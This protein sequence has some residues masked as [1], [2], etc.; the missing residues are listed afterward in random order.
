M[1][2]SDAPI[3]QSELV[4]QSIK[5]MITRGDLHAGSRLPIEKDLASALG[6][7]ARIT[8]RGSAGTLHHGS[9]GDPAG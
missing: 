2:V 3:S 5:S 6:V 8:P 7:F 9:A 1:T 4:V